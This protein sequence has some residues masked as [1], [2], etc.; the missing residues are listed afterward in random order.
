MSLL[1]S[2]CVAL[3]SCLALGMS[4]CMHIPVSTIYKLATFDVSS[5]D[6]AVFRAAVRYSSGLDVLPGSAVLTVTSSGPASRGKSIDTFVL[7]EAKES[8]EIAAIARYRRSG[9]RIAVY[10]LNATDVVRVQNLL[11]E[12]RD[13][14]KRGM[15]TGAKSIGVAAAAC[16]KAGLPQGPILTSTYL[17][18]DTAGDYMPVIEDLDLRSQLGSEAL[19]KQ[20]LPCP[21]NR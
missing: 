18:L 11:S 6:P 9:M 13:A 2:N 12:H 14:I 1:R 4:G 3:A 20:V 7:E 19:A 15:P 21:G 16:H 10:R 8:G 5:A 17:R